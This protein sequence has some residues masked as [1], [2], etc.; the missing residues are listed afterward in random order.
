MDSNDIARRGLLLGSL[1]LMAS[2]CTS[3]IR[4]LGE[5]VSMAYAA[6]PDRRYRR[7]HVRYQGNEPAGTIVVDTSQRYLY[8]VEE[9]GWAMR[10][11]IGVGEEGLTLKGKATIGRKAVWPSWTPT[12][13]MLR[14][15]PHLQQYASG[16][17]GGP[18]NPLGASALYLYRGGQDTMFRLHGTNQPWTIGQAVSSG[19]IRLT[20][21]DIVDLYQRTPVGTTVLVI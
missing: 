6:A 3:T 1:A 16:V 12:A 4:R 20:N 21:E 14:R 19:C 13:N 8:A 7:R 10:Y 17:A 5:P 2:G 9:G 18:H 15:K 11:G